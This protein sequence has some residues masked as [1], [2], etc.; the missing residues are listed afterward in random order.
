MLDFSGEACPKIQIR[1]SLTT[2]MVRVQVF[3]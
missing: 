3:I 2:M 1:T